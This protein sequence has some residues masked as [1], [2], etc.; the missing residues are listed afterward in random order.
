MRMTLTSAACA[1][2]LG[3]G[4]AGCIQPIPNQS[5]SASGG[6]SSKK[7]IPGL[8]AS[9]YPVYTFY[10]EDFQQGGFTFVYGGATKMNA[11]E[12]EGADSSEFFL[13]ANLDQKDYS[14]VAVCLWNMDFDVTPYTKTGALVFQLRGKLGDEKLIVG[15]GDDEKTNGW[16]SV[17]R[18]PLSKY[19]TVKKGDWT[20]F[21]VPLRDL[22]KRGVAWDAAHGIEIPMPFQWDKVQEF[23]ILTNKGDNPEAEVDIDN[24]QIWANAVSE[25]SGAAA[26]KSGD[27]LDLD[28][29]TDG[30]TPEQMKLND[31]VLGSFF[32]DDPAPGGFTYGYGGKTTSKSLES[33]TPGN[34][35][36]WAA[37]FDND[38]SGLNISLGTKSFFDL[39]PIRRTGSLTFWIKGGPNSEKFYVG[40][41]DNEG[42]DKKVQT[43]V[44]GNDYAVVKQGQWVQCRIPLKAFI[45]DGSFWDASQSRE[46]SAKIDWT[47]IQEIRISIGK[48]EN[49]VGAGNPVIFYMDQIQITKTAKG[50]YDPDAYWDAFKSE[51]PDILITDF[52]KWTDKWQSNHGSTAD[53]K[54]SIAPLPKGAPSL[55]KG[56]AIKIDFKPGDWFETLLQFPQAEGIYRDWSKHYAVSFW[57]YTEKPYQSVDVTIQDRDK[58]YFQVK[59]GATRGWHQI[60]VPFRTFPKFPYY[61]PPDAVQ[62]NKLDLDGTGVFQM[63]FKPGGD[64][65]GTVYLANVQITNQREIQKIAGQAV[66]PAVFKGNLSKTLQEIPK[67]YGINVGLWAPELMDAASVEME[68]P[69]GLGVVRYPGGLRADEEDWEK[70]IKDKDFNIDTDEFLDWCLK[71]GVEPMFT[72]DV[73]DGTPE[74][75][76][77]WI[78]YVNK[79][80][81]QGPKV[82]YWEIGN[83]VYGTWH[84]YYEKWGKD[85]GVA[86]GKAVRE[87]VKA[88]KTADP[89]IKITCVWMLTGDWNKTVFKEVADLVDG[90]NVHHYAQGATSENDVGL[91]AVSSEADQL[92]KS[93]RK[94]VEELGVKGKKYDIWL[95]EWNSVDFNPGP[96]ILSHV[97]GLFVAD[98]L[99][100]LAQS[101]IQI[102]NLWA[103]YN[104]RDKRLGDYGILSTA[105]DPQGLNAR[106]PSYCAMKMMANALQ[107]SLLE[108]GSD[109]ELLSSWICKRPNGKNAI[110]LINKNPESDYKTTLKIPGLSGDAIVE[111]LSDANSGGLATNDAT[112]K[113]HDQSG[114]TSETKKL[115]DGSTIVV[116][117]YSIVT[118]KFQ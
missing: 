18:L 66:V 98:Y 8:Q 104:G 55:V 75:A 11:V 31:E 78:T 46:I 103:L 74:R 70:T 52:T 3:I 29:T 65:P 21:V 7:A 2:L 76:A 27:W 10:D 63:G 17:V 93:V 118:I 111:T 60:L 19:G 59:V 79:T 114:P 108:G 58:E 109:Q 33:T 95:T 5:D 16:K 117:K 112:G 71:V 56:Q 87:F 100:H 50:L 69:I 94:Q 107:G 26:G 82:K 6:K 39:T 86:Y 80:R 22:G 48:D 35:Q 15:L 40:L 1:A 38:W 102:A 61:Q 14:G 83:E 57:L 73:G 88:M 54:H 9:A 44:I 101:P 47:K 105:G 90:V 43:K 99:G 62:N 34:A 81:T 41:M 23:R 116:P 20:T 115:G 84:K 91:L 72:A 97:E 68:K 53:I 113:V 25:E 92:M 89:S 13:H 67:I 77:K 30:P 96:Q 32:V 64:I 85:G 4:L 51:A 42:N 36:V 110:V 45:D 24:V 28:K 12:G 106:R 49:K 37:Y